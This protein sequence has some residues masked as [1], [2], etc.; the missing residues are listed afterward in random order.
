[1]AARPRVLL[2]EQNFLQP[3]GEKAGLAG[4]YYTNVTFEGSPAFTRVDERVDF[5]WSGGSPRQ[6]F[7]SANFSVRWTGRIKPRQ[8]GTYVF[9]LYSDDGSRLYLDNKLLV[10]NWGDRPA[11]LKEGTLTL[12]GGEAHD[13]RI[14]YYQKGGMR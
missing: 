4:A 12:K 7:P 5:S 9:Y 1:M 13:I 2:K 11:Q 6:G 14:D 3:D 10:D 8:D